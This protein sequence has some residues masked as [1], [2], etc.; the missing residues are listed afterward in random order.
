LNRSPDICIIKISSSKVLTFERTT[1][2][3]LTKEILG[4]G[5]PAESEGLNKANEPNNQF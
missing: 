5:W 3:V 1:Y 2:F 4:H